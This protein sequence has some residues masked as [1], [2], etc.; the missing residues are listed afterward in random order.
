MGALATLGGA[1]NV[2]SSKE[3]ATGYEK[4]T[5]VNGRMIDE[6]FDRSEHSGKYS[7]VVANRFLVEADG[8]GVAIDDLKGAVNTVGLDRLEGLAHGA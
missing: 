2:Q 5:N 1:L 6:E 4:V 3:T 8:S 7:V